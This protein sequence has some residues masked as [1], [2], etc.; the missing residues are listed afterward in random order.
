MRVRRYGREVVLLL[1]DK[2]NWA[3]VLS[4]SRFFLQGIWRHIP[5][6]FDFQGIFLFM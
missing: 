1:S 2:L 4:M 3:V 6:D 5:E